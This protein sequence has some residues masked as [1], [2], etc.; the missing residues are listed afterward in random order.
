[1]AFRLTNG[2]VPQYTA[3]YATE[4]SI[5]R[6]GLVTSGVMVRDGVLDA[7]LA[8]G[9]W[10]K[11]YPFFN[12]LDTSQE[13]VSNDDPTSKATPQ[14]HS[15]QREVV[16]RLDRNN[17][18][19][20]ADY[21]K[22]VLS[23][24]ALADINSKEADYRTVRLQVNTQAVLT[25]IFAQNSAAGTKTG[26]ARNDMIVDKET[27]TAAADKVLDRDAILEAEAQLGDTDLAFNGGVIL[28]HK[29]VYTNLRSK[30]I[31]NFERPSSDVP[32]LTYMGYRVVVDN[33]LPTGT[34]TVRSGGASGTA[35][36]SGVNSYNTYILAPGILRLGVFTPDD[37]IV[38][39]RDEL[40]GGGRG[41]TTLVSRWGLCI[42]PT[43]HAY[44][45]DLSS[46]TTSPT[47]ANLQTAANWARRVD[48]ER[49]R[50]VVI[51]T[52]E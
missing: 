51:A 45:Q 30:D 31:T 12:A 50:G 13:N 14:G 11:P 5:A 49:F 6:N 41:V 1:M 38:L 34:S 40:G 26:G 16:V 42:H 8:E 25:G 18:W 24:D 48:R 37:S 21:T 2:F 9:G 20:V 22:D 32:F 44:T 39:E 46:A 3:R 35:A 4:Q 17:A 29:N 10:S 19:Q 23:E 27:E 15:S 52:R 28:M 7:F 43:G 36:A 47:V 33:T